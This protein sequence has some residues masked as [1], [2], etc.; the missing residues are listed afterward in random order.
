MSS[1]D[2][3]I[4]GPS[5]VECKNV[6]RTTL[7]D[8]TPRV[9][10]QRTRASKTDPCSRYYSPD[11]FDIVAACLHAVSE[12]WEFRYVRPPDLDPHTKCVGKLSSNVRI[13][14]RWLTDPTPI[15]ATFL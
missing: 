1:F 8:G 5:S 7:A 13:D 3:G 14:S 15:L 11:D 4:G 10:F 9:D 2:I 6:L 12:R